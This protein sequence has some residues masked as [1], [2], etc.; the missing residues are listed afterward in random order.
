MTTLCPTITAETPEK[1]RLQ[2]ERVE[3]FAERIHVDVA[4]GLLAPRKLVGFDQIWWRGDR[5]IDLHVMYQCPLEHAEILLALAP[6][7]IILHAEAEGNFMAFADTLHHHGIEAG[8]ALLPE[9]PV[10]NI[11]PALEL[12]DH[13]LIF[14]GNLGYQ[15]GSAADLALLDKAK[16]LRALKPGVEIGWDGGVNDQ[17]ARQLAEGGVDVLNAGGFIQHAVDPISAYAK[18]EEA[19][20]L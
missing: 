18:L 13:V 10:E 19:I 14:S 4:D 3:P 6:R 20:A 11:K 7:L 9:T 5:T 16:Q 1:Y 12:I 17:N 2:M 8:V 15:G